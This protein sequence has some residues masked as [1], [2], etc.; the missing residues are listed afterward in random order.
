[1]FINQGLWAEL[2]IMSLQQY[3]SNLGGGSG[4]ASP[5]TTKGDV[6][7]YS[8]TNT[9]QPVGA[10]GLALI[11]DSTQTTGLNY[12]IPLVDPT[13][14]SVV[15]QLFDDFCVNTLGSQVGVFAWFY[16]GTAARDTP[17]SSEKNRMGIIKFPV[18]SATSGG[19]FCDTAQILLGGATVT[20]AASTYLSAAPNAT[21]DYLWRVGLNDGYSTA[22]NGCYFTVDRTISASNWVAVTAKAGTLT[23]TDTGIAFTGTTWRNMRISI[24]SAATSV[25]FYI[26]GSLVA[27]N[28][29]NIP[30]VALGPMS[31]TISVASAATKT[32]RLDWMLL[33]FQPS[34]ARGTF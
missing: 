16:Q 18:A 26:D 7:V 25:T 20:W 9:R 8:S 21:D 11:A 10:D 12:G 30:I 5:L 33:R 27:T 24:N 23:S 22:T 1:M 4:T 28:T 17:L 29:T 34:S 3:S 2:L 32:T 6:Y 31:Y 15:T 19:M 13:S 14:T